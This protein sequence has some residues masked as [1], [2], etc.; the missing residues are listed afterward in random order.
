MI[1]S[2]VFYNFGR[3]PRWWYFAIVAFAMI[4][5]LCGCNGTKYVPLESHDN[6]VNEK[7]QDS[8]TFIHDTTYV[9][10]TRFVYVA[11]DT[12]HDVRTVRE[13]VE[14]IKHDSIFISQVDS[15]YIERPTIVEVEKELSRWQHLQMASGFAMLIFIIIFV[16]YIFIKSLWK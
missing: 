8:F 1:K 7:V 13:Y 4:I 5:L 12:V 14:R 10:R 6:H 3:P 15:V 9:E 11:G 16:I 2:R